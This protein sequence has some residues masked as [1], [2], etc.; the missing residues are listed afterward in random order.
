MQLRKW[1]ELVSMQICGMSMW[2]IWEEFKVTIVF[3]V[4]LKNYVL[5]QQL[6]TFGKKEI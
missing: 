6:N 1:P 3:G 2:R 5:V 4:S